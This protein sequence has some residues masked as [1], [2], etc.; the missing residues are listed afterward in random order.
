[1]L[2]VVALAAYVVLIFVT[3]LLA[4]E[5]RLYD[6]ARELRG[7]DGLTTWDHVV[8]LPL[9]LASRGGL[10][11]AR[12]VLGVFLLVALVSFGLSRGARFL[13]APTARDVEL[14]DERPYFLYLRSFDED[15]A[16]IHTTFSRHG[17]IDHIAPRSSRRFEEVLV[18]ELSRYAPVI[19]VSPPGARLPRL[20]AAKLSLDHMDWKKAIEARAG[21]ALAVVMSATPGEIRDGFDFELRLMG[22]SDA[23]QRLLLVLSPWGASQSQLRF[24]SFLRHTSSI[25]IFSPIANVAQSGSQVLAHTA[26]DGWK[27]WG[28]KRH[29]DYTYAYSLMAAVAWALPSWREDHEAIEAHATD[30]ESR[31]L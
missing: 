12:V 21:Q 15:A 18:D 5:P 1:L 10:G 27:V 25:P 26:A 6:D 31:I 9:Q 8:L 24:R 28:S 3:I 22:R 16:R 4:Q 13:S 30:A 20:G 2:A 17:L 23:R 19:A 29:W 14:Q 11:N 7:S